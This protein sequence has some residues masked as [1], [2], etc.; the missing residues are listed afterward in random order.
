MRTG[1]RLGSPAPAFDKP[2][3]AW[4]DRVHGQGPGQ[5]TSASTS[6]PSTGTATSPTA[7]GSA[8][9]FM[10]WL[11]GIHQ[12]YGKP[13]WITEFAGLNWGWLHHPIT[14]DQNVALFG[15]PVIP[16]LERTPWLERYCWFDDASRPTCSPTRRTPARRRSASPTAGGR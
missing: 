16:Q 15:R 1:L 3:R 2:G 4:A 8:A 5:A 13:V 12:Q 7:T 6:S 9:E 14:A 10:A 11:N